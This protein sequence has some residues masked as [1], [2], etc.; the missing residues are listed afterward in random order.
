[1]FLEE[2]EE[3]R[4]RFQVEDVESFRLQAW[5]WG[6]DETYCTYLYDHGI[7]YPNGGF[8]HLLAVG[9]K[10]VCDIE[11]GNSF[12]SVQKFH[13]QHKSWLFGHWGYDL[14]NEVELL[15]S[16]HQDGIDMANAFFYIPKTLF[17][18][19][20]NEVQIVSDGDA[21]A[22][23]YQVSQQE[24]PQPSIDGWGGEVSPKISHKIYIDT[25]E[26]IQE[27]IVE[28]D[29]YEVNICMEF[30]AREAEIDP[31]DLYLRISALSPAPFS[32]FHK[33]KNKF[34][35]CSSPERYMKK[36]DNKVISQP[37]KGTIRRGKTE[38]E[39]HQLK[40]QLRNDEKEV[41][42]NMMIVDLVRNDLARTCKAGTI[43]VPEIFGIYG[44][45][46]VFQMISTIEGEIKE[47]I[48]FAKV[49]K[50]A[51]PM[52]S[53][54]GAPKVMAMA[55]IETYER[56][57]RGLY[58]GSIGYITPEG[59]FDFNVV[60][61]SAFYNARNKYLSFQIGSAITIDSNAELEYEECLLKAKGMLDALNAEM[62][63]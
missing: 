45:K 53:M 11:E 50:N 9:A 28:G 13:N 42:E 30:L 6:K 31:F 1:M 43:K 58:S 32:A 37:I 44:F 7:D 33:V 56:T 63:F 19:E 55:L 46:S 22:I 41:A 20:G 18:F 4:M 27:H 25:V 54:T 21:E 29:V 62:K 10:K 17:I 51:F 3:K 24:V 49:L 57:K 23:F 14:K 35:A 40:V 15:C 52:G 34:V 38:E 2:I 47:G 39:D 48:P 60:I 12:E 61:R 59:D 26:R 16:D 5:N 8:K 36:E